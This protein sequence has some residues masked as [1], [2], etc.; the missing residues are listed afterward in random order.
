MMNMQITEPTEYVPCEEPPGVIWVTP[1]RNQGQIVEIS[2]SIGIPA[3]RDLNYAADD[4][5]RYKRVEDRADGAIRHYLRREAG[6]PDYRVTSERLLAY[7]A[8]PAISHERDALVTR[9]QLDSLV[10]AVN[11]AHV[12]DL[13]PDFR[14]SDRDGS[15]WWGAEQIAAVAR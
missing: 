7:L 15:L 13:L 2:Y 12:L 6:E 8:H 5:A 14:V 11:E 10:R 9:D 4:G 1:R 3:G